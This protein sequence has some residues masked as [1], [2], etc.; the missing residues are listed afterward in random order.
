MVIMDSSLPGLD[1]YEVCRQIRRQPRLSQPFVTLLTTFGEELKF[2]EGL[3][4][5]ADDYILKPLDLKKLTARIRALILRSDQKD[6]RSRV[7]DLPAPIF[8]VGAKY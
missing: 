5:G 2:Q 8:L 4:R 1:G 7:T 3:E 6:G